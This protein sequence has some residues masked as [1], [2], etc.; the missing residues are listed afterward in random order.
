MTREETAQVMRFIKVNFSG[1][2]KKCFNRGR[3]RDVE[4]MVFDLQG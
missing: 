3:K 1:F 4:H 2:A